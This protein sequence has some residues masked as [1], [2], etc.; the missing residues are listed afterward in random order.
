M[1]NVEDNVTD[2]V[3]TQKCGRGLG[4]MQMVQSRLRLLGVLVFVLGGKLQTVPL[5]NEVQ[6]GGWV[7]GI[8]NPRNPGRVKSQN[9]VPHTPSQQQ[10]GG[11]DEALAPA[12]E[13][14]FDQGGVGVGVVERRGMEEVLRVVAVVAA[15]SGKHARM[16]DFLQGVREFQFS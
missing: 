4:L 2:T 8:V 13:D 7:T 15:L 16:I 6:Q 9:A 14:L 1:S 12:S 3:P 5:D 11:A 10:L